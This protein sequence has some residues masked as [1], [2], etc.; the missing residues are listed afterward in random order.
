MDLFRVTFLHLSAVQYRFP[1]TNKHL[2]PA[3]HESIIHQG[4]RKA[5]FVQLCNFDVISTLANQAV[6]EVIN[7]FLLQT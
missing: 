3:T 2:T 4:L 6:G 5:I 1:M 7:Q